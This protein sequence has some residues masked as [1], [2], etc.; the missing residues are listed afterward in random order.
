MDVYFIVMK[1]LLKII[2]KR[3]WFLNCVLDGF[4]G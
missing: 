3:L 4:V 1:I 2:S